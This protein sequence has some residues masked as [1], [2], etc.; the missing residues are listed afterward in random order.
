[1]SRI[2]TTT[3]KAT[4]ETSLEDVEFDGKKIKYSLRSYNTNNSVDGP[5]PVTASVDDPVDVVVIDRD[6]DSSL[7]SGIVCK[8]RFSS[9]PYPDG[10]AQIRIGAPYRCPDYYAGMLSSINTNQARDAAVA[11]LDRFNSFGLKPSKEVITFS[12][13]ELGLL[14]IELPRPQNENGDFQPV[15]LAKVYYNKVTKKPLRISFGERRISFGDAE[16][17]TV[18]HP[19]KLSVELREKAQKAFALAEVLVKN[20]E[21]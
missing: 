7:L 12:S 16:T 21:K 3:I 9:S 17:V 18:A 11:F 1:M 20:A 4:V 10:F 19:D 6:S 8:E 13:P 2:A 15:D 14:K 5:L